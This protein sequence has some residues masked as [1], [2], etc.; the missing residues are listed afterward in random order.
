MSYL[1]R[2]SVTDSENVNRTVFGNVSLTKLKKAAPVLEFVISNNN[3]SVDAKST[4]AQLTSFGVSTLSVREVYNGSSTNLTLSAEPTINSSSAFTT[5]TKSATS[6][7]YP[8]MASGT[9]SVEL[10]IT[11]SVTDSEGS[12]REVYGGV[13]LTKVKKAA[14]SILLTAT[15]QT[16]TVSATSASVQTGTLQ[17]VALDALE[18][19]TS[20]FNSASILSTNF[21]GGSI[22][23][24]TLTLGTIPNADTAGSASIGINYTDSEGTTASKT[25]NVSATK[26]TAGA[27]GSKGDPGTNG[28]NGTDGRRTTSGMVHYQLTSTSAPTAPSATSYNFSTGVFS[29]LTANWGTGAPTY[30]SGNSNKYWYATYTVVETTAGGGTGTP[31]FGTPTQAIGFSGLVSFSGASGVS[32]G[33][34]SLSFG[35]AGTTLINGSNISTGKIISTNYSAGTPYTTAGTII[36][37]DDG[38]IATKTFYVDSSGN[39]VFKGTLSAAAG[40]FAGNLSAAGGT[41]SGSLQ[42]LSLIHI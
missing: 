31:T 21:T 4:G 25:I 37:L 33:T 32:D 39:A 40:T 30:A 20:V 14:P 15:P 42:A 16:Q 24:R 1:L 9:N 13:S 2:G 29:G 11:G 27:S 35:V 8:T 36:D 38:R 19:T 7:T 34:N 23:T 22:S 6:L 17:T 10:F 5:I 28:T 26:A 18:G 12:A 3:Q 41:F